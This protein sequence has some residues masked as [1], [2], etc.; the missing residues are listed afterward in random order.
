M[1]ELPPGEG[2]QAHSCGGGVLTFL[3]SMHEAVFTERLAIIL[4]DFSDAL[5]L[6]CL[7]LMRH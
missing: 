6:V 3:P 5:G 4:F 1:T 2:G 7:R